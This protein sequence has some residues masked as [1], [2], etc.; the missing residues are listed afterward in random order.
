MIVIFR[1]LKT[2]LHCRMYLFTCRIY[3]IFNHF[4]GELSVYHGKPIRYNS[5]HKRWSSKGG[6][7]A[8]LVFDDSLDTWWL[9]HIPRGSSNNR[10]HIEF[11]QEIVIHFAEVAVPKVYQGFGRSY[12]GMCLSYMY[13]GS[14]GRVCTPD[15]YPATPGEL[16]KLALDPPGRTKDAT[17]FFGNDVARIA[18]LKIYYGKQLITTHSWYF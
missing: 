8:S 11:N 5:I 15:G 17:F 16:I 7:G 13:T 4:L 12:D 1:L 10:I 3:F 18:D 2:C 6:S 14:A 9:G